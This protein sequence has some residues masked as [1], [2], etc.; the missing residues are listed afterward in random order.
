MKDQKFLEILK[1]TKTVLIIGSRPLDFDSIGSGLILKKYLENSNKKVDLF[2]PASLRKE[3]KEEFSFLPYFD[4]VT[5]KDTREVLREKNYDVLILIDGSNL[6][7][8]YDSSQNASNIPDLKIYDKIIHIDHHFGNPE[9]LGTYKIHDSKVS[10][11]AELIATRIIPDKFID[12]KIA[13]LIYAAIVGDTG[14][15]K[16]NFYPGTLKLA[17]FLLDHGAQAL[18]IIN[19]LY[20]SKSKTSLEMT[21]FA[22][23]NIE[24]FEDIGTMFL[25]LPFEKLKEEEID[26]NKLNEL[27]EAFSEE[28]AKTVK[29]YPRGIFLYEKKPGEVH[30]SARGNNLDNKINLPDLFSKLGGNGGGHFNAT[31]LNISNDFEEVKDSLIKLIQQ[32]LGLD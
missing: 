21:A 15:F 26:E 19:N 6:V 4:E 17:S 9:K 23:S 1:G 11:T 12:K 13:T 10:S 22:I 3:E 28:L 25:F 29:G 24:Y 18:E 31:A 16:W 2:F 14:N 8:F 20:F 27:K 30:I 5:D 7:Q 32:S